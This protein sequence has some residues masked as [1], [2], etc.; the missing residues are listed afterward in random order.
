MNTYFCVILCFSMFFAIS[1]EQPRAFHTVGIINNGAPLTYLDFSPVKG[2]DF[3]CVRNET[4]C[5]FPRTL[6]DSHFTKFKSEYFKGDL[7]GN[8]TYSVGNERVVL[9]FLFKE[10]SNRSKCQST[11]SRV[12]SKGTI[13]GSY[14]I[15]AICIFL[16]N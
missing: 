11:S 16:I 4:A 7:G 2:L 3:D 8:I 5:R 6:T 13:I 15:E 12:K 10:E 1:A 14:N 9:E